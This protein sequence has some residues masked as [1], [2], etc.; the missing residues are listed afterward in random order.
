MRKYPV[1]IAINVNGTSKMR[2]SVKVLAARMGPRE[3]AKTEVRQRMLRIKSRFHKG[4]FCD[5]AVSDQPS[6]YG[7]ECSL[8]EDHWGHRW[9]AAPE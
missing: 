1:S 5:A 8:P 6:P 3:V 4:Q 7:M 2:E 9:V